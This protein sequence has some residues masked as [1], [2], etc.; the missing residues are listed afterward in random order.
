MLF[1]TFPSLTSCGVTHS[2]EKV[3]D[4]FASAHTMSFDY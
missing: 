3:D 4:I 2:G 1:I